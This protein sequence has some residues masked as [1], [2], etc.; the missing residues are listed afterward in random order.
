MEQTFF[1][2]NL[3]PNINIENYFVGE[4]NIY[5]FKTLI[6]NHLINNNYFLV[7][8]SKSGKTH[9]SYI[10]K[11][12][13]NAL[14]YDNNLDDILKSNNNILIENI[15]DNL[16][17]ENI[18]H[19]INYC[20]NKKLKILIN[21]KFSLNEYNFKLP[22]LSSRLKTFISIKIDLPDD[23]LLINLLLKL[24]HDKQIIIKNPEIF[25]YIIKRVDRSYEKIFV[26]VNK[27]DKLL[28]KKNKQLT[29]PLI[30]DLI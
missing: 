11:K 6:K 12:K 1:N 24:F 5:A 8:P 22:D 26:L 2:Y 13:Y 30:K 15:F 25:N 19:I 7:G 4:S 3:K 21:S 20:N 23:E 29:I 16:N 14:I 18:F 17:E 28:M 10:W 27:I 9:L